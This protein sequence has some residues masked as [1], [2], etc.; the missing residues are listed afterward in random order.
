[1][2][3]ILIV[4]NSALTKSNSNGRTLMNFL[5]NF[6]PE[7]IAQFYING[8]VD[9]NCCSNSYKVSDQDAWY[10]FKHLGKFQSRDPDEGSVNCDQN[11]KSQEIKVVKR[12]CRNMVLRDVVWRSYF[13]WNKKFDVFILKFDPDVVLFQAGD[14]PFLYYI[15]LKISNKCNIPLV[16]YNSEGYVLKPVLYAGSSKKDIWHN[17]LQKRLRKAYKKMMSCVAY[18]FYI[19]E[20]LETCYQE[21]YPHPNISSVLYTSTE[22]PKLEDRSE[23]T[24]KLIYCGNLGVGRIQPLCEIAEVL[25]DID[26]YATLDVYGSFVNAEDKSRLSVYPNVHYCGRI[27]YE[28]IPDVMSKSNLVIHCE[29]PDRLDNLKYAFSTKIADCLAS[30]IPFL[31]YASRGFPFVRY[32]EE[33]NAC[34]IAESKLE[35]AEVLLKCKNDDYRFKYVD[36]AI[37]LARMNHNKIRNSA[38]FYDVIKKV[39][40]ES[41]N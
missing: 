32:L 13:W 19:T 20:E 26:S 25:Q 7:D 33:H 18:C 30:G 28:K 24:F 31:V 14:C 27:P 4:S 2:S 12:N 38:L 6:P 35:L 1:M 3:R 10:A 34:H 11:G 36:N 29:N 17:I 5:G 22:M 41:G 16:M 8:Q 39:C 23:G 37:R 21:K 40:N 15:A 9:G